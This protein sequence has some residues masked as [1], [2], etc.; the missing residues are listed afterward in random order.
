MTTFASRMRTLAISLAL[1]VGGIAASYSLLVDNSLRFKLG[2]V[3]AKVARLNEVVKQRS[4][5]HAANLQKLAQI[6]QARHEFEKLVTTMPTTPVEQSD[7][8]AEQPNDSP[9]SRLTATIALLGRHQLTCLASQTVEASSA[10]AK[11]DEARSLPASPN[12]VSTR[13]DVRLSLAGSF[14]DMHRAITE[15]QSAASYVSIVSIQ[16]EAS[17]L[18]SGSH[19]WT[20][21]LRMEGH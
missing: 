17:T 8:P 4:L 13:R 14:G 3:Q 18:E 21:L 11:A 19:Q 12:P 15:I 16:M 6:Q 20:I 7:Q 9:L 2:D 1:P 10:V 5:D